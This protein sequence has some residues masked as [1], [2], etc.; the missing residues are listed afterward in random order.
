MT[1]DPTAEIS[2]GQ[3]SCV[4]I[5]SAEDGEPGDEARLSIAIYTYNVY[6]VQQSTLR[7]Y[8]LHRTNFRGELKDVSHDLH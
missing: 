4:N 3:R 2:W 6:A 1:F 7:Y 8:Q 5:L